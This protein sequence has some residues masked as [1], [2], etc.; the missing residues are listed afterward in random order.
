MSPRAEEGASHLTANHQRPGV[1]PSDTAQVAL[2]RPTGRESP[3]CS[4]LAPQLPG[5]C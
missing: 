5:T 1:G 4:L 2:P 3:P